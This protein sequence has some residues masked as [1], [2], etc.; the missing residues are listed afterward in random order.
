M[1]NPD[2]SLSFGI[3]NFLFCNSYTGS[4]VTG[5]AY[6]YVVFMDRKGLILIA[7]YS[8]D[9]GRF[10]VKV[11]IYDDVIE[12]RGSYNYVLPNQLKDLDVEI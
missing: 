4:E 6:D 8:D 9:E 2:R 10:C 3:Q 12:N 1:G 11:G 5:D 7:R